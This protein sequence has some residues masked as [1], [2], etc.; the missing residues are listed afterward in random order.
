M[1]FF[2]SVRY[3]KLKCVVACG[4][5]TVAY[6]PSGDVL[7]SSGSKFKSPCIFF[8]LDKGML[9]LLNARTCERS[10]LSLAERIS[11]S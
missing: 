5:D 11:V 6:W 7:Q 1:F 9:A 10:S 2:S 4:T 8:V 3:K